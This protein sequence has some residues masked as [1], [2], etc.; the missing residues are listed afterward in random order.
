[1]SS[2]V[3]LS[4]REGG[5]AVRS[6]RGK[7]TDGDDNDVNRLI[8]EQ[9]RSTR[10]SKLSIDTSNRQSKIR[11]DFH[12]GLWL[13]TP[14]SITANGF[15]MTVEELQAMVYESHVR[16]P[17]T[18]VWIDMYESPAQACGGWIHGNDCNATILTCETYIPVV[19]P[20]PTHHHVTT[21]GFSARQGRRQRRGGEQ[22]P[23]T[24]TFEWKS[25]SP[26]PP[27]TIA[28]STSY[29]KFMWDPFNPHWL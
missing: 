29:A 17:P 9:L 12:G 23:C 11:F 26:K 25:N 7:D 5:A 16:L 21:R 2:A 14:S 8:G 3:M 19:A 27:V 18:D 1:M 22:G 28:I 20:P 6:K 13:T 15:P 4:N 24:L 10:V